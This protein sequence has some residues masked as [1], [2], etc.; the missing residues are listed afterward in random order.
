MSF[1]SACC[2]FKQLWGTLCM[3]KSM[4][5]SCVALE[6]HFDKCRQDLEDI[7]HTLE[8]DFEQSTLYRRVR[9]RIAPG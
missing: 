6:Q 1:K 3:A 2:L 8:T 7:A 4:H 5:A 9:S